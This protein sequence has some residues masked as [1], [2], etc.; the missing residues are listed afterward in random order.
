MK[1]EDAKQN[2]HLAC[3]EVK[4]YRAVEFVVNPFDVTPFL[5]IKTLDRLHDK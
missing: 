3:L 2:F 1:I 5:G 4:K